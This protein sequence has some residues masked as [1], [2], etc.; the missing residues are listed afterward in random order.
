M[1]KIFII[2]SFLS[3]S[4]YAQFADIEQIIVSPIDINTI[5]VYTN[6]Y[7]SDYSEGVVD[8]YYEINSNTIE[9]FI[10]YHITILPA[11]FN[12]EHNN[13]IDVSGL[14]GNYALIVRVYF[15]MPPCYGE[16]KDTETL[17]LILPLEGIVSLQDTDIISDNTILLYPNPINDILFVKSSLQIT[18]IKAF[19]IL[20]DLVLEK[21]NNFQQTNVS[22]LK[23]S[24]YL[25]KIE[26]G[27]GVLI[28]KILKK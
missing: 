9:L 25:I 13:Q 8:S 14:T 4:L 20:G 23:P 18:S 11:S 10:C 7:V 16:I 22:L 24:V 27:K 17:N 3:Q 21:H 5:N 1:K 28:N 6:T 2:L 19:S 15:D 12:I 26:T